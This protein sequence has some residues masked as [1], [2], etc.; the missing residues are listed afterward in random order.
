MYFNVDQPEKHDAERSHI[1]YDF[2]YMKCPEA[3]NIGN[4][5]VDWWFS[6]AEVRAQGVGR[7]NPGNGG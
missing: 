7:V 1:S 3:A 6:R 2:I 4:Q 5:E